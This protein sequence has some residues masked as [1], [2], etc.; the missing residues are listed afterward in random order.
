MMPRTKSGTPG[1]LV[2]VE[3]SSTFTVTQLAVYPNGFHQGDG[4]A[5]GNEHGNK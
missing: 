3:N 4:Y 1:I 5:A 2:T